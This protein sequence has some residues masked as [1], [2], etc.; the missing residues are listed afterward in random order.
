MPGPDRLQ[1]YWIYLEVNE[2]P[3]W[4]TTGKTV[5][6]INDAEKGNDITNFRP[7]TFEDKFKACVRYFHQFFIFS[8]IDSLSKTMKN[9]YFI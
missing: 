2:T 6:I 4:L 1:R 9:A 5:L 8:A 3:N 7:T